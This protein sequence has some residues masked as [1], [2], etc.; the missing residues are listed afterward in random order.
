MGAR[1][2]NP[3]AGAGAGGGGGG[4]SAKPISSGGYRIGFLGESLVE[5]HHTANVSRKL[6]SW[7]RGFLNWAQVLNPG[8]FTFDVWYDPT[9]RPGWEPGAVGSSV[10]F[11][12]A[13]A[14]VGGQTSAQILARKEF[15]LNNIDVDV[16]VISTGTNSMSTDTKET[17]CAQRDATVDFFLKAGKKVIL[18]PILMRDVSSWTLVSGYREKCNYVN[19]KAYEMARS[20]GNVHIF[21]WNQHWIDF[22]SVDGNPKAGFSPDGIHFNVPSAYF[23]GVKF[24]EFLK[25]LLPY[26]PIYNVI[27]PN[28]LWSASN[29]QGNKMPN[30]MMTGTTGT[31]S[32]PV[33][34]QVATSFRALRNSAIGCACAASKEAR[35][36]GRG[37]YQ[38]L[39]MTPNQA[40]GTELFYF[41]TS[42]TDIAHGLPLDTWVRASV[43]VELSAWDGWQGVTLHLRDNAATGILAYG[44]ETYNSDQWPTGG[45]KG[46]IQTPAFQLKDA[47]STLRWMLQIRVDNSK[48]GSGVIKVGSAELRPV[49]DPRVLLN[50]R[51][52]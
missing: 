2:F 23:M 22:N 31:V 30:P 43:E 8:L 38:V 41:Q 45:W 9:S 52:E 17:I 47:A 19:Q 20:R 3:G 49:A 6:S 51:G 21:D 27:A 4:G 40:A 36:D 50:Y 10:F 16:V 14:G 5:H 44:M 25:T 33:T 18:L 13:N 29:P 42:S 7:S 24:A 32:A 15:L 1:P 39:T 12:G 48:T 46:L 28:D 11:R 26:T 35:A 37:N 34:G